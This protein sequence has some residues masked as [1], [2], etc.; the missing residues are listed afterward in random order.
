MP[1]GAEVR[2][3]LDLELGKQAQAFAQGNLRKVPLEGRITLAVGQLPSLRVTDPEGRSA[4][5]LGRPRWNR[6]R[7]RGRMTA[8]FGISC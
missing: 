3:T 5:A 1:A 4:E 6:P 8:A 2:K 7:P